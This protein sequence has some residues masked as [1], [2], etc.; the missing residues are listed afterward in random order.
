[1]QSDW[2]RA[3]SLTTR[4]PDFSQTCGFHGI[5]GNYC[6]SFKSKKACTDDTILFQNPRY[7]FVISEHFRHA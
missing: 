6:T 3:F 4:E 5:K 1:M 2:H 7:G